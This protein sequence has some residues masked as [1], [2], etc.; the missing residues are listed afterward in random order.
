[1]EKLEIFRAAAY[2]HLQKVIE[3][4]DKNN[5][6]IY[7]RDYQ[8][9]LNVLQDFGDE[10]SHA[11]VLEKQA[12]TVLDLIL[13]IQAVNETG[14]GATVYA[15]E[16]NTLEAI[17]HKELVE[18]IHTLEQ[19][20]KGMLTDMAKSIFFDNKPMVG[21]REMQLKVILEKITLLGYENSLSLP[22]GAKSRLKQSCISLN[23]K[24]FTE[25]SFNHA[26]K[27][28]VKRNLFRMEN[29]EKFSKK[30]Y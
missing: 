9:V 6:S 14:D 3:K 12:A 17:L 1:M 11:T 21:R 19:L 4:Y 30:Y 16:A 20:K 18:S 13:K 27:E 8:V 29:S 2:E 23:V 24:L 15:G 25:S 22:D 10:Y 28:G 26:W 5:Q 7:I